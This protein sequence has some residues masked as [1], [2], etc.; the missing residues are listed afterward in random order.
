MAKRLLDRWFPPVDETWVPLY[1]GGRFA[2][3]VAWITTAV[4]IFALATF[5]VLEWQNWGRWYAD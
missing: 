1:P 5:L 4:T 3:L 2:P